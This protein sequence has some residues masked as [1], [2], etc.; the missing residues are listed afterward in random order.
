M[1]PSLLLAASL[2]SVTLAIVPE[3]II[4]GEKA[5]VPGS[6]SLPNLFTVSSASEIDGWDVGGTLKLE[7]GRL[8]FGTGQGALW[9]KQPLA[10]SRDEWVIEAVFRNS[11]VKE[12]ADHSFVDTNGLSFWLY[13]LT[14]LQSCTTMC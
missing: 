3:G 12:T 4:S 7:A 11:E 14:Q 9:S 1:K 5:A 8:A 6:Q 2:A 10:N 13:K